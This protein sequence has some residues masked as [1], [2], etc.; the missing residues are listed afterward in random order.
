[1]FAGRV[2]GTLHFYVAIIVWMNR[3]EW[4]W[5]GKSLSKHAVQRRKSNETTLVS[6]S[7]G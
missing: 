2:L 3:A 1:M 4:R 7:L 5:L 6:K